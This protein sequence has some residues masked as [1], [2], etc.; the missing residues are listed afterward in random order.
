MVG[1]NM[2][3]ETKTTQINQPATTTATP[4][5]MGLCDRDLHELWK[6]MLPKLDEVRRVV[7]QG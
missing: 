6:L 4:K 3:V 2:T 7:E 1:Q 5:F